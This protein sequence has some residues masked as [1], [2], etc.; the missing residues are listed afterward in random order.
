MWRGDSKGGE[1]KGKGGVQE[2]EREVKWEGEGG[3]G[4]SRRGE[5]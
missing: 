2:E 3:K 1:S 4:G 5:I